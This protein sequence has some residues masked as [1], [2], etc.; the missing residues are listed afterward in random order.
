MLELKLKFNIEDNKEYKVE[1]IV[2]SNIYAKVIE[3][4]LLRLYYLVSWKYYSENENI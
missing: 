2:D 3:D 1:A 4:Y